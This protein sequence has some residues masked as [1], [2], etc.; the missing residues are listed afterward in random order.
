MDMGPE[1]SLDASNIISFSPLQS[2]ALDNSPNKSLP[3]DVRNACE[4]MLKESSVDYCRKFEK[5]TR[6]HQEN[7][8]VKIYVAEERLRPTDGNQWF[9]LYI[10][11]P[12]DYSYVR[13]FIFT[14]KNA[15]NFFARLSCDA[16][17]KSPTKINSA[18]T[19]KQ[20]HVA[21]RK[22][23]STSRCSRH[24]TNDRPFLNFQCKIILQTA[25]DRKSVV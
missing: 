24:F 5:L 15:I 9:I 19:A 12:L 22:N 6:M 7:S 3:E 10:L 20:H 1:V 23:W 17:I 2:V 13:A 16:I 25:G 21:K 18:A 4:Q 11:Y 14:Q 8:P